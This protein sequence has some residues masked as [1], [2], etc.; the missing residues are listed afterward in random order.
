MACNWNP[1]MAKDDDFWLNDHSYSTY[2]DGWKRDT[3]FGF[4]AEIEGEPVGGVWAR[5]F[6]ADDAGWGFVNEQTP[7]VSIGTSPG[8][9]GAGI[10]RSLLEAIIGVAPGDLSLSVEDGNPAI[11]L[12]QA[13]G[14]VAVGRFGNSTT[15]VRPGA[16]V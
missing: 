4:V 16:G 11:R 12:Y 15:M 8:H 10:G 14:F 3:D 9:R 1:A 5:Y 2:I 13:V 7:E 6:A